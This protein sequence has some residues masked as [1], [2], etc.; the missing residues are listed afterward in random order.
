[1]AGTFKPVRAGKYSAE[2][3]N[4]MQSLLQISPSK[5]TPLDRILAMPAMQEHTGNAD[6]AGHARV[7][8]Q[9]VF[10]TIRVPEDL[11]LLPARLPPA[12]YPEIDKEAQRRSPRF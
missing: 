6:A 4:L 11:E 7:A 8:K 2:L 9:S 5:R 10:K 1:M 12:A 3:I